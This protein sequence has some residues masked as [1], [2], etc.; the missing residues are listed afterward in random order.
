MLI[1]FIM[2]ACN[3][4]QKELQQMAVKSDSLKQQISQRDQSV[5]GF[6]S[7]FNAIEQNLATIKEKE[8]MISTLSENK[9]GE[10]KTL[11]KERIN[12]DINDIYAL[13]VKNKDIIASLNRKIKDAN[14]QLD[15]FQVTVDNLISQVA[16]R[17]KEIET[18]KGQLADMNTKVTDLSSN[19]AT[20]QTTTKDQQQVIEKKTNDLNTAYYIVGTKQQLEAKKI[21][22]K[23]GGFIGLGKV[24]ELATNVNKNELIKIDITKQTTI[25]INQNKLRMLTTHPDGSY[26]IDQTKDKITDITITDPEAFWSESKVLVAEVK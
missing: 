18:M 11:A 8:H 26:K 12:S 2:G 4:H 24:P 19:V 21:I 5:N 15:A 14:G 17:D 25:S 10:N 6:L 13:L 22:S 20:L 3:T 9:S 1:P 7:D 16:D 23:Q